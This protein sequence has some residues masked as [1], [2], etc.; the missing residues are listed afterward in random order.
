[1]QVLSFAVELVISSLWMF[2]FRYKELSA[3]PTAIK[4]ARKYPGE[5][6][7]VLQTLQFKHAFY[8]IGFAFLGLGYFI[9]QYCH[10]HHEADRKTLL[11]KKMN[12]HIIN[13]CLLLEYSFV[14]LYLTKFFLL[15]SFVFPIIFITLKT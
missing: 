1:M 13:Q 8:M 3:R 14:L 11:V 15:F 4:V 7:Q 2:W 9:I 12:I 10:Y 6:Q 5:L